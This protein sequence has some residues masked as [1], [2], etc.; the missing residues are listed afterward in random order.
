MTP[1][2]AGFSAILRANSTTSNSTEI[3]REAEGKMFF[4]IIL[5][6]GTSLRMGGVNKQLA[7]IGG[8]P[9]FVLSALAFER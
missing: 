2:Y 9:V 8:V 6:A 3:L 5:A 1:L 4:V 7:E